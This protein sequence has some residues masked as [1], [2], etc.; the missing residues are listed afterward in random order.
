MKKNLTEIIVI[1][2]KS[3]S[4]NSLK[5]DTIGS[6][7]SFL[8][9]QKKLEGDCNISVVLFDSHKNNKILCESV[10]IN[11][12]EG[13][14][15]ENYVPRGSTALYDC[16][17]E[18]IKSSKKRIKKLPDEEKPEKIIVAIITD[19]AENDSREYSKKDVM[20][21]IEKREKKGWLIMYLGSNQDSFQEA[22][23]IGI[24]KSRS[25]NYTSDSK[26][27]KYAF[28][29]IS[30][31][32]SNYRRSLKSDFDKMDF[33]NFSVPVKDEVKID[34]IKK[35]ETTDTTIEKK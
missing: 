19:G 18:T 25:L 23:K 12:F 21:M 13:L 11:T 10:D 7:N 1:I 35:T 5:T 6:F 4:M 24:K 34:E 8:E 16:I 29:N 15:S 33:E 9:E 17:G 30:N 2:D 14:N 22:S 3:G 28:D 31:L 26:G 27:V 20:E 32:S